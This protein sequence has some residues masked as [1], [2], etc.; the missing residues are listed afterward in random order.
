[1]SPRNGA[2]SSQ[3]YGIVPQAAL[4]DE[5]N[6]S[7]YRPIPGNAAKVASR[8]ASPRV[9]PYVIGT[10]PSSATGTP[11]QTNTEVEPQSTGSPA[12]IVEK[13]ITT[14]TIVRALPPSASSLTSGSLPSLPSPSG[15]P[16]EIVPL[17]T[18]LTGFCR[19]ES[20]TNYRS[21]NEHV[22]RTTCS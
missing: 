1:M 11:P 20:R 16:P 9:E 17:E 12:Q 6:S 18:A 3:E 2:Q 7:G 4:M 8:E 14:E 21:F 13:K 22:E 10:P 19:E 15:L 5:S